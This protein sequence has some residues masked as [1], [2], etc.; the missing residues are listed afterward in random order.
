[1]T[2]GRPWPLGAE[3]DGAGVN[4]AVFSA[5]ARRVE[6][7]LF[8]PGGGRE[9][10]R[11]ALPETEGQVW[12][13]RLAGLSP[14]ACYGLRAYGPW[15]PAAGHRFNPAK[16]LLDPHARG[17]TGPVRW[18]PAQRGGRADDAG[19]DPTDSA[20]VVPKAVV[21]APA[22]ALTGPRPARPPAGT[23]IYEAH[24]R[25]LTMRMPG[26][27]APGT[28]AALGEAPVI[29]HLRRLGVTT[30]ELMPLMAFLDDEHLVTRGLVNYWGYQPVVWGAPEPRHLGPA[31]AEGFREAVRRLHAEGIEVILDVVCNHSGEGGEDGP[32]LSLRGLDNASY[33]RLGADG[34]Y[35]DDTGC[36]NTLDA[37]HPAV[38]AL[39]LESLRHWAS[40]YGIDGFRF[41]LATTLGR[42]ATGFDA[43]APLLAALR[44]DPL[45][46]RLRLVAEPWD[47]GPGGYRLGAFGHPFLEWNDRFRDAVR[48][49]WRG[50][51]GTVPELAT[52]LAGSAPEFD[53][54]GRAATSSVNY[55]AAHD[56]FTLADAVAFATRRNGAN[57]EGNRDGHAGEVS[58]NLGVEGP[59]APPRIRAARARRVR[60]MLATLMV[61]Q[62]TP[63]LL[64]GDELGRSQG[65]NNNAYCQDNPTTWIDWA[66]ADGALLAF[67]ARLAAFRRA[68]PVLRQ[69]LFLHAEERDRGGEPDIVWWHE[70]GRPMAAADW[71]DAARPF[72]A[73]RLHAAARTPP[74][75][76]TG[77]AV[78]LALNA[79]PA[80]RLVLPGPAPGRRWRLGLD[81]SR[82]GGGPAPPAGGVVRVPAQAVLAFVEEGRE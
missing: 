75:V 51:P 11:L 39:V 76:E 70:E 2:A 59:D 28:L 3:W 15:A 55:V 13:G 8:E 53:H 12:F 18:H 54:G 14:G 49:F 46:G 23:L 72:L 43:N 58:D 25:G 1:M 30:L 21:V 80:R 29:D 41:D 79:G 73:L 10:A 66:A 63:M 22:G 71:A 65:G 33:Y 5:H 32:T 78:L 19:P 7:C 26:I 47:V 16:L 82:P 61:A 24:A 60:A 4:F 52:R 31:G 40:A 37:G 68:H 69:R 35:V 50:D 34:R 17:L 20:A 74:F 6:V 67:V 77:A 45:L 62:G 56:G 81:S 42:R 64:A 27:A 48:R 36:G 44:A 38:I 57:G 9:T